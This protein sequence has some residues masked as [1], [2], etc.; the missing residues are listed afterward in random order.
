MRFLIFLSNSGGHIMPG[1]TFGNYLNNKGEKVTYVA[2]NQKT[3]KLLIKDECIWVDSN[4]ICKESLKDLKKLRVIAKDYDCFIGC[5]GYVSL[6]GSIVAPLCKKKLFLFEANSTIGES[7]RVGKLFA[8]NIFSYYPFDSKK[9]KN[10][11]S[12]VEDEFK[13]IEVKYMLKK[14]L[15]LG[16]S[17]GSKTLCKKY[18]N[19]ASNNKDLTFYMS[20]GVNGD[21]NTTLSNLIVRKFVKREEYKNFDLIISRAGGTTIAE[22][23]KS[24]VPLI[25]VP[26]PYVKNDH[27]RKNANKIAKFASVMIAEENDDLSL[28]NALDYFRKFDNRLKANQDYKNVSHNNV[29]KKAYEIIKQYEKR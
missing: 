3:S 26:S 15:L 23:I 11:G 27:Q 19:L 25:L 20:L 6:L 24:G 1:L 22:V 12:P 9:I 5:G 7:N 18:L 2:S 8:K 16:G 4:T 17:Q 13:T 21:L 14:V 29:C 28:Q 10:I